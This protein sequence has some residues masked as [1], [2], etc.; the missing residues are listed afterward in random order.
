MSTPASVPVPGHSRPGHAD[1]ADPDVLTRDLA[2]LATLIGEAPV[3][4]AFIDS[5]LRLR[6]VSQALADLVGVPATTQFGQLVTAVWPRVLAG[7]TEAAVPKVVAT[8]APLTSEMV[9]LVPPRGGTD[10]RLGSGRGDRGGA[11]G[12]DERLIPAQAPAADDER[13]ADDEPVPVRELAVAWYPAAGPD[14]AIAGVTM[15][16][17]DVTGERVAAHAVR[18]ARERYR[19]LVQAGSQVVWITSATGEIIEDSPEWRWITGQAVP[20]YLDG[21]WL[22]AVHPDDRERIEAGWLECLR[23]GT[24]FDATYR[25]RTKSGSY[26]YYEIRAV[27]IERDGVIVEWMGANTDVTSQR[28]A[29]EMRGR[30]TE[31]LSAAALRTSRLQQATSRL[32]E[33]LTVE[34]VVAVITE[35]GELAIGADRSAVAIVEP[36]RPALRMIGSG[37][38]GG[39]AVRSGAEVSLDTPSVM[40]AV[41]ASRRPLVLSSPESLRRH[42]ED[43]PEATSFLPISDER[44]WAALPLT[45]SGA[46]RGALLFSFIRPRQITDE[47]RV[48]LEALAGQCALALERA[49]LYEREHRTAETLQRNL[50]PDSLPAVPGFELRAFYKPVATSVGGDWYDA[51]RLPD[52]RLAVAAGDVMGKGL[53]AAAGMG[54]VRSALRALALTDP[55]PAAVLAGLDR[56]FLATEDE[57]QVT[58]VCYLVVDPATGEGMAGNAGHLPP[59]RLAPGKAPW[60]DPA[61]AGTPL[62]WASPRRQYPFELPRGSTAVLYSDGLVETRTR[63]LDVG[64]GQLTAVA[65]E[66][67]G[68]IL[69]DPD[70]LIGFLVERMLAGYVQDDD[71]TVL[72]LH[73]PGS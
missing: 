40:T 30:L 58:T 34:Q 46:P 16:A 47:E 63:G 28:E 24:V 18:R 64:L 60:L 27:P 41:I 3:A 53:T 37:D 44:A 19:S 67:S 10:S 13:S 9:S 52:G 39:E 43:Q 20:E 21:G 68:E 51:F 55:R 11:G 22:A 15:I 12:A 26:R 59:L 2:M 4:F 6:S 42:F 65:G 14:G 66:A 36:G 8:G 23:T 69:G 25:V 72:V 1:P 61:E 32:A 54:R 70:R 71:V 7:P 56:L 48:F 73:S 50:L 45:T 5:D 29:D 35:I 57:E 17:V 62:G 38:V 33:A 49:V 31:Q